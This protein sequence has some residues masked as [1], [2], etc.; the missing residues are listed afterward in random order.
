MDDTA[1]PGFNDT[2][3]QMI[4][5]YTENLSGGRGGLEL[6]TAPLELGAG[7]VDTPRK[8][9]VVEDDEHVAMALKVRLEYEG[10]DVE[11]ARNSDQAITAAMTRSPDLILMDIMLPGHDGLWIAERLNQQFDTVQIPVV[12]LTAS[13]KTGLWRDAEKLGAAGFLQKPFDSDKLVELIDSIVWDEG[14]NTDEAQLM[15]PPSDMV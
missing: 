13:R 6:M 3:E 14:P 5:T 7:L 1:I 8:V 2:Q 15:W 9:L 4:D 10:F 11:Q 12:F